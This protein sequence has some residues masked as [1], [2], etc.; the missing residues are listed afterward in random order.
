LHTIIS[1]LSLIHFVAILMGQPTLEKNCKILAIFRGMRIHN[2]VKLQKDIII[3]NSQMLIGLGF[4][5][6]LFLFPKHFL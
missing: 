4:K 6:I 2:F 1:I 5:A 3:N